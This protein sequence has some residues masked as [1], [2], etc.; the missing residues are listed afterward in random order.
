[1]DEI[2]KTIKEKMKLGYGVNQL[3]VAYG[4]PN[5]QD[6]DAEGYAKEGYF[7]AKLNGFGSTPITNV[8]VFDG[9][10]DDNKL[11]AELDKIGIAYCI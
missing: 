4:V 9:E 7:I 2:I 3:E 1:M 6:T 5:S 8:L 11:I 10:I